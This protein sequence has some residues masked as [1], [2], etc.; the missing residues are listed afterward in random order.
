MPINHGLTEQNNSSTPLI[1]FEIEEFPNNL[2]LNPNSLQYFMS[3][4]VISRIPCMDKFS[5]LG[6]LP[7]ANADNIIVLCAASIPSMS[8]AGFASA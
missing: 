5:K 3:L 8:K 4:R 6:I 2:I 7:Y 1:F